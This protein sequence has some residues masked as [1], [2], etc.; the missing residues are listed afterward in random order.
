MFY[1]FIYILVQQQLEVE[2]SNYELLD[3]VVC[4]LSL[5]YTLTKHKSWIN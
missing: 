5:I 2:D 4:Q 3:K 1:L